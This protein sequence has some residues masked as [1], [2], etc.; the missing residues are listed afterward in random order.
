MGRIR[1]RLTYANVMVTLLAFVVL[2]G[3]AYAAS[4]LKKNSV[5]SATIRNGQVKTKDLAKNAV[6]SAKIKDGQVGS[7]DVKDGSVGGTDL[8]PAEG[9]H[10]VGQ[11][12]EPPFGN[13]GQGDCLWNV[14]TWP[15]S[16]GQ[17][18]DR[19]ET[20]PVTAMRATRPSSPCRRTTVPCTSSFFRRPCQE[21]L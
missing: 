9:F 10:L 7:A 8:T 5:T 19:A 11:P 3:G 2:G 1:P 6:V 15:A 17:T 21:A 12:G 18:T 4:K 14:Y 16:P 13:G 20:R